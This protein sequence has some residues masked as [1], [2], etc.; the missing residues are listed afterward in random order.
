MTV[1]WRLAELRQRALFELDPLYWTTAT[2]I[3]ARLGS[4]DHYRIALVLE[5]LV[6][7]GHAEIKTPGAHVRRFRRRTR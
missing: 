1:R 7:D 2:E 5:R 3:C 4:V 6:V